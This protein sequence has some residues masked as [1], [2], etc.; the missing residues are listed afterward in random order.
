MPVTANTR[1]LVDMPL[2]DRIVPPPLLGFSYSSVFKFVDTLDDDMVKIF[3]LA[4]Q[5]EMLLLGA[6]WSGGC[7]TLLELEVWDM[8]PIC[9]GF[10]S[11]SSILEFL[12]STNFSTAL[13]ELCAGS[14]AMGVGPMFLGAEVKAAVDHNRLSCSHLRRNHHGV[15]VEKD[16]N[17]LSLINDV[18][19]AAGSC[20]VNVLVGYPCQPHSQ[21]GLQLRQQDARAQV[22]WAALRITFLLQAQ[23]L[24]TECV[25]AAA[26]DPELHVGLR[27]LSKIMGWQFKSVH[28]RL[29]HQWPCSR[30]RWWCALYPNDWLHDDLTD[31]PRSHDHSVVDRILPKW[32]LFSE[33][34]ELDLELDSVEYHAYL[35]TQ[36]G[37]RSR[38]LTHSQV[39]PTILHSYGNC[40]RSCP[41]ECRLQPFAESS[42]VNKGL[43]GVFIQ[44]QRTGKPRFL[45]P[46]EVATLLAVPLSMDF[47]DT[48]R[49]MLAL[50]GLAASP[51]QSLWVFAHVVKAASAV[52]PGLQPL[53]PMSVL[54]KYKEEILRQ[55]RQDF[56]FASPPKMMTLSLFHRDGPA[57]QLM[58]SAASTVSQLLQAESISLDWGQS[59][60]IFRNN[61]SFPA[62]GPILLSEE[63]AL[64][65]EHNSKRQCLDR[66]TG[67]L[68]VSINL[69]SEA[70]TSFLQPGSF[71][72]QVLWEHDLNTD[73]LLTDKGGRIFGPDFKLWS[74]QIFDILDSTRFPTIRRPLVI[75]PLELGV[76][77]SCQAGGASPGLDDHAVWQA[78][79][80]LQDCAPC[81]IV[82]PSQAWSILGQL[83]SSG[84]EEMDL[85]VSPHIFVIFANHGH[86]GL[87]YGHLV[88]IE[89]QWTYL[90][91]L[92]HKL[93]TEAFLLA[94]HLSLHLG[95]GFVP[96]RLETWI[97]Q[98][99]SIT[100]GT[101]A[102][103]HM[104][105]ALGLSGTF[106]DAN[107]DRLHGL[108]CCRNRQA[109]WM[110]GYG[111]GSDTASQLSALLATKGVPAS[112]AASRAAAA[113]KKLGE[114]AIAQALKQSNSWQALKALATKPGSS[115]Q[116]VLKTELQE[117]IN[118]KAATKHGAQISASKKTKK[119]TKR[120]GVPWNL[121]PKLLTVAPGHFQDPDGDQVDQV[122]L[123]DVVADARGIALRTIQE[124]GPYLAGSKHISADALALL[125][126]NDIPAEARGHASVASLRFPVTFQ[127]TG[128][129]L[130]ISGCIIQLGDVPV[131]RHM[132]ADPVTS[133]DVSDTSVM[134][135]VL[136]RDELGDAWPRVAEG[137]IKCLLQW[138]PILR[139]CNNLHCNHKCGC[140]HAAVEDSLD[141][142]VHEIWTRRFQTLEGKVVPAQKADVFQAYLRVATAVV[143]HLVKLT[144][145]GV[146]IEPRSSSERSTD[147]AYSVVWVPGATKDLAL[148]KLKLT[149]FGLS[150]VRLKQ[151]FGIRVLSEHEEKTYS[152]IR[153]GEEFLKVKVTA[154]YRIHPLPHGLQ[155][156][157]VATL[158]QKWKWEAKPLQPARGSSE[159]CAWDIGSSPSPPAN[160][161]SAFAKDVLITL[162][163]DKTDTEKP[164]PV[165]GHKRVQAHLQQKSSSSSSGAADPWEGGTDPWQGNPWSRYQPSGWKTTAAA[166]SARIDA[167]ADQLEK[168]VK[169]R[170][171]KDPPAATSAVAQQQD[172]RIQRLESGMA[173]LQAQGKQFHAWFEETGTRLSMQEQTLQQ[174]GQTAVQQQ[175]DLALVRAE[176]QS[177]AD[178][179]NQSVTASLASIKTELSQELSTSLDAPHGQSSSA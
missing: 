9:L 157:Q 110:V 143:S 118:A 117:Y 116:F 168:D 175:A 123:D 156:S 56:P 155:R 147:P 146:Y 10:V 23:T 87:L 83:D 41:C 79:L 84:L 43:R 115:F 150:L 92:P 127:P 75:Q 97:C 1:D 34:D 105:L 63:D 77:L 113:I 98:T 104:T 163:K 42:L 30:H 167:I 26:E 20:P 95:F 64:Y 65:V 11:S 35:N 12:P 69:G 70:F 29:E 139:L 169:E 15:V 73:V 161:M 16:L 100:C 136:Y 17:D 48:P 101:I 89:L 165:V 62:A 21:Q 102:I 82:S 128:D 124:A 76:D 164:V 120:D 162:M 171:A 112:D 7:R 103:A 144:V 138:V 8:D 109:S 85:Q 59:A 32:G 31:W 91:G 78:M 170:I 25:S 50:L 44:S 131:E 137:P 153:P 111:P 158:L 54:V 80:E 51:L 5:R 141:N 22:F 94:Q 38:M 4:Q 140:Y 3:D 178:N 46:T 67:M 151:R 68:M 122:S 99:S 129:P 174:L 176:V 61:E 172:S 145:D 166:P 126:I 27:S 96:V 135:I 106:S 177:S 179:M 93:Q 24:I 2:D 66:P 58:S 159:G 14:G 119:V 19:A 49:S 52:F 57:I 40:F 133:M 173:E 81:W 88:G 60:R 160:V 121:D 130:L 71:L 149:S 39:C 72:F 45:H 33:V 86:W 114:S 55:V 74:S 152:E 28:L 47:T 37:Q 6:S 90:D 18:F 142:V 154:V 107:I 13:V 108:L 132:P 134:K 53:D 125:V 36:A 148:H